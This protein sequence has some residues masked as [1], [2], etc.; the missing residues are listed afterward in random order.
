MQFSDCI[1]LLKNLQKKNH[2]KVIRRF[3]AVY[4]CTYSVNRAFE[5][6]LSESL[7]FLKFVLQ[8]GGLKYSLPHPPSTT[9]AKII[10]STV[11]SN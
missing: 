9:G 2:F 1:T 3:D 8:S 5:A 7:V 11:G 10:F 4:H 6:S